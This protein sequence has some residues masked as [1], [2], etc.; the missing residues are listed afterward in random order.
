M[1]NFAPMSKAEILAE[2]PRLSDEDR[3]EILMRLFELEERAADLHG[4]GST[5]RNLLDRE[6]DRYQTDRDIGAEWSVV[7]NRLRSRS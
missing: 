6:L 2:L 4:P 7:E 5:E 1:V 3:G